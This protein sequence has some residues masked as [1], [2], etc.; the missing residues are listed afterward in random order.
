MSAMGRKQTFAECPE[1][2]KA[3]IG[4]AAKVP[5]LGLGVVEGVEDIIGDL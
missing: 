2:W 4:E 1:W 5:Q 3:G